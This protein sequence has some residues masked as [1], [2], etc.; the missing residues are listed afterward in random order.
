MLQDE[1]QLNNLKQKKYLKIKFQDCVQ[2][3]YNEENNYNLM[4]HCKLYYWNKN[5]VVGFGRLGY[6]WSFA[7]LY[8]FGLNVCLFVFCPDVLVWFSDLVE[9]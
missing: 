1:A 9:I 4:K 8:G 6:T 7:V 5:K 2:P 3:L